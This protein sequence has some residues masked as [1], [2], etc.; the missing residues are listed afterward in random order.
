MGAVRVWPVPAQSR[1]SRQKTSIVSRGQK[2]GQPGLLLRCLFFGMRN[3]L[4]FQ[5]LLKFQKFSTQCG[6]I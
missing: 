4:N 5:K 1:A 3:I 6:S 2:F